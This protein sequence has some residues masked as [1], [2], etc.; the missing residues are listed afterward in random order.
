[1]VIVILHDI[2]F[3]LYSLY[4]VTCDEAVSF[5]QTYYRGVVRIKRAIR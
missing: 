3:N 5:P 1:M 2:Q 4:F